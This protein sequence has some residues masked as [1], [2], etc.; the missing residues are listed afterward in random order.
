MKSYIFRKTYQQRIEPFIGKALIK[1]FVGQRRVGKSYLLYQIMDFIKKQNAGVNIIYIN[2]ELNEFDQVISYQQLYDYVKSKT[3]N[4]CENCLLIDEIQTISGFENALK[5]L[6]AEGNHDIY[7]TGSN[8]NLLSGELATYLSGRYIEFKVYPLSYLESLEF[9]QLADQPQCL[10]LYLKYGGLPYLKNLPLTDDIVFD[11]LKNI[12]QAILFRDVVARFNVRNVEFLERLIFYLASHTGTIVSA[13][14]ISKFLKSQNI[15]IS[16]SSV[17]DYLHYLCTAFF[18]S[19]VNR[20]DLQGKKVFEIGEK[21][22]FTDIGLRN[23][24]AG[25]N[26]MDLGLIIENAVFNHLLYNG[27]K[28]QVGQ[29]NVKEIDFIAEKNNEKIYVQVALRITDEKTIIREFGNLMEINDN[30]PKYVV[31]LD[32]YTGTSFQG[33][34]HVPLRKFLSDNNYL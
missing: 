8:A 11:Y 18:I 31:T 27:Y 10:D 4:N 12:Y 28:V 9:H 19:R 22:Y 30:Y 6:L 17:L 1:I 32:E 15:N 5:S 7:C 33:I 16:V 14:N 34:K 13:S 23:T 2:K 26:P 25:F 20:S 21:Y 24:I 3:R 29:N